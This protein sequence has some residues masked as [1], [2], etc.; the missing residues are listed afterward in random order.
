[1]SERYPPR[2]EIFKPACHSNEL[3][4][5]TSEQVVNAYDNTIAYTDYLLSRQIQLLEQFSDRL[6]GMLIYASDHGESLGEQGLY[7]HGL[8]YTFAPEVQKR[9]PMLLWVSSGY[10]E[11]IGLDME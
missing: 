8:P 11:R 7:L 4:H 5:C 10:A 2:F 9:V 1:Y 6:D 3:Q